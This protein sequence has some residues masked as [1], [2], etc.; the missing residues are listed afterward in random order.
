MPDTTM[1]A[2]ERYEEFDPPD[3]LK[4]WVRKAWTYAAP[5]PSTMVQRIAPDGCPELILDLGAPY[6][7]QG[8]DGVFRLQPP[9]VFAG[10]MT[11]PM[12]IRPVGPVE[13]VAI[14]FRPD[15]ARDWLGASLA[16]ATDRRLDMTA[17]LAGLKPPPGRPAAQAALMLDWLDAQRAWAEWTLDPAVRAQV[18]AIEAGEVSRTGAATR[19]LQR[20]FLDRTG[21]SPRLLRSVAR[22]RRVF[23]RA[24]GPDAAG[25]LSAGLD[26]G[27]F[28]QP[29]MARDFRRFLG[30]TATVWARDQIELA[31]AIA[32]Q[33]Y[34]PAVTS[35][36]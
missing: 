36:G 18:D 4:P 24:L 17:R 34:K 20:R 29:Q 19:T 9:A 33:T 30:C 8:E 21:V 26:A 22:F 23:D 35:T 15:G 1:T 13:L 3:A 32:S 28:D 25:W 31:R 7:E 2:G 11:R 14:R 5:A 10:Q 6:E 27:Y 12:A 16:E